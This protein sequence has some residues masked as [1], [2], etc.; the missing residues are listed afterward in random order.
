MFWGR[1]GFLFQKV[2]KEKR[3]K[4]LN[5]NTTL[6]HRNIYGD[7]FLHFLRVYRFFFPLSQL[8]KLLPS[9]NTV[10]F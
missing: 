9:L 3:K 1:C 10:S 5:A 4:I 8:K 6:P 7:M 2:K